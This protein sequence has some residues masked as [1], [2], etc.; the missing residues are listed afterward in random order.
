MGAFHMGL[1]FSTNQKTGMPVY[2]VKKGYV[3][4]IR[5]DRTGYGKVIY[6]K[7]YDGTISVYAHLSEFR[8]SGRLNLKGRMETKIKTKGYKYGHQITFY[9]DEFPVKQGDLIGFS[10]ESGAGGPHLHFEMRDKDNITF[11]PYNEIEEIFD[12]VSPILTKLLIIPEERNSRIFGLEIPVK[13]PLNKGVGSDYSIAQEEIECS[14][15]FKFV[16]GAFD[17]TD[18][19]PNKLG[20]KRIELI[21]DDSLVY[22]IDFK[23]I[24]YSEYKKSDLIYYEAIS[25]ASEGFYKLFNDTETQLSVLDGNDTFSGFINIVPG[26]LKKVKINVFDYNNNLSRLKFTLHGKEYPDPEIQPEIVKENFNTKIYVKD[27]ELYYQNTGNILLFIFNSKI[28][29]RTFYIQVLEKG[30]KK[31]VIEKKLVVNKDEWK[32]FSVCLSKLGEGI[33]TVKIYSKENVKVKKGKKYISQIQNKYH[34]ERRYFVFNS[35]SKQNSFPFKTPNINSVIYKPE[36]IV[37]EE[38]DN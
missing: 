38:L 2:A 23:N 22:M 37:V 32:E 26:D 5:Q 4:R 27:S 14:G 20:V 18:S 31:P 28:K 19:M 30:T 17:M 36:K 7:H 35:D 3:W 10:G 16:L 21:I 11:L 24:S 29:N 13:L 9:P 34:F 1:D 6:I 12:E 8:G 15:K 25:R 33:F